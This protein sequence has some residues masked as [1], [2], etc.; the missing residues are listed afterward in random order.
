[1]RA[2]IEV[3]PHDEKSVVMRTGDIEIILSNEEALLLSDYLKEV[4]ESNYPA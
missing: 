2:F 4:A 3:L 1:M